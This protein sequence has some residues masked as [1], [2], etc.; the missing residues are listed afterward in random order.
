MII[1]CIIRL[2]FCESKDYGA[3]NCQSE[4]DAIAMYL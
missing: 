2:L 4:I 3:I 1:Y